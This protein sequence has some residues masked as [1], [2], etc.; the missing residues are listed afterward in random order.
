MW[1]SW[2]GNFSDGVVERF[3]IIS[4]RKPTDANCIGSFAPE[5]GAGAKGAMGLDSK[6]I[7]ASEGG[8]GIG[9]CQAH[10]INS[11]PQEDRGRIEGTMGESQG[12]ER[13][14]MP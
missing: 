4:Q 8:D 5:H 12:G 7:A 9:S 11:G 13:V 1:I 2:I 10:H 3:G 14:R 6:G